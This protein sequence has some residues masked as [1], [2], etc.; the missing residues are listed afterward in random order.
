MAGHAL[1]YRMSLAT[2]L[3]TVVAV[4]V[5]VKSDMVLMSALRTSALLCCEMQFTKFGKNEAH[6]M[7]KGLS[8]GSRSHNSNV[9]EVPHTLQNVE[10]TIII[11]KSQFCAQVYKKVAPIHISSICY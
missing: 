1:K 5:A 11:I 2:P 8:K 7:E 9:H 6:H 3:A 10:A 4:A